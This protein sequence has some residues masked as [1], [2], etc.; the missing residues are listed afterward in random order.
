MMRREKRS[1]GHGNDNGEREGGGKVVGKRQIE[2]NLENYLSC[3]R[4]KNILGRGS[5]AHA[6]V[7]FGECEKLA[8]TKTKHAGSPMA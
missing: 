3:L 5:F 1:V 4:I 2:Q 6:R 7:F 8:M